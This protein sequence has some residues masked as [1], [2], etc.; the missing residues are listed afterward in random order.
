[1]SLVKTLIVAGFVGVVIL[2]EVLAA[3]YLIPSSAQVA[4]QVKARADEKHAA[5]DEHGHDGHGKPHSPTLEVELGKYNITVHRPASDVTLRINFLLIGT[6][7]EHDHEAFDELL[8]KNQHRLR[9]RII[10]EIR[11]CDLSDLTDPGLGLIKRRILAKSNE[12]LGKPV[13][14]SVV[15]SEFSYTQL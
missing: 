9:D 11:N 14:Q 6:I 12:L 15:F 8:V 3:Y 10:F 2:A 1:M 4:A 7:D 13:L 5:Q